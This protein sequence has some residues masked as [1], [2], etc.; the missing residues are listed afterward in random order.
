MVQCLQDVWV[1]HSI[2]KSLNWYMVGINVCIRHGQD[3][4]VKYSFKVGTLMPGGRGH[5]QLWWYTVVGTCDSVNLRVSVC[6]E[7]FRDVWVQGRTGCAVGVG[8][9]WT[10]GTVMVKLV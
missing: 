5:H 9:T 2:Q 8:D 10:L 3:F 4:G 1:E 7:V 6:W